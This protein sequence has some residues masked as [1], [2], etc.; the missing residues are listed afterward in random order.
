VPNQ[1]GLPGGKSFCG[2]FLPPFQH[3]LV[4]VPRPS[5][6]M[7]ENPKSPGPETSFQRPRDANPQI[8][9]REP[10]A[11]PTILVAGPSHEQAKRPLGG[12]RQWGGETGSARWIKVTRRSLRRGCNALPRPRRQFGAAEGRYVWGYMRQRDLLEPTPRHI[13]SCLAIRAL[14]DHLHWQRDPATLRDLPVP[15]LAASVACPPRAA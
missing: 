2:S 1:P 7:A 6:G 13:V 12:V 4:L 5:W 10:S 15:G 14:R 9:G 11:G 8:S 3:T